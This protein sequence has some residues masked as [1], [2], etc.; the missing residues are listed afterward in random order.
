MDRDL[1]KQELS[2]DEA[3]RTRVYDDADGS[4]PFTAGMTQKGKL[5]IGVGWNLTDNGLPDRQIDELLDIGIDRACEALDRIWPGWTA[6]LDETRQR[7]LA[8]MAF[9]MGPAKLEGFPHFLAALKSGDYALA[10]QNLADSLWHRQ[11]G[12]RAER[13]EA[14]IRTGG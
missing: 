14:M 5:T 4:T 9:N 11:V 8:N 10:A 2:R 13:I 12:P 3:R 6:A 1:L 7:A